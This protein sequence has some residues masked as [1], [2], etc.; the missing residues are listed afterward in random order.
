MTKR[1]EP[2]QIRTLKPG[3]EALGVLMDFLAKDP[4]YAAMRAGDLLAAVTYQLASGLHVAGVE[5]KRMVAYCGW[6]HTST[7]AGEAWLAGKGGLS[8]GSPASDAA[9]LTI[10]KVAKA[11]F[12]L[13]MIRACRERNPGKRVFFKRD[14]AASER[15][16]RKAT[17]LNKER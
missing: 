12:L 6:L 5:D 14:Y 9:A 11:E 15:P 1:V 17:V 10:V 4:P 8:A 7:A 2:L 3:F 13:P 16:S